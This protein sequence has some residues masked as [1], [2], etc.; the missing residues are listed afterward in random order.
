MGG[1]TRTN[2]RNGLVCCFAFGR[3]G[4]RLLA[5]LCLAANAA[6]GIAVSG[7]AVAEPATPRAGYRPLVAAADTV[8][9][10]AGVLREAPATSEL[11]LSG[12]LAMAGAHWRLSAAR[13]RVLGELAMPRQVDLFGVDAQPARLWLRRRETVPDGSPLT[14]S[15]VSFYAEGQRIVYEREPEQLVVTGQGLVEEDGKILRG[16]RLVYDLATETL[17]VAGDGG[18]RFTLDP[19]VDD[20][21]APD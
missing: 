2:C 5:G 12:G 17:R 21:L 10:E 13:G 9:I 20:V 16:E 14:R 6:V 15:T 18:V 11:F 8:S 3:R 19:A 1:P 7:L 4:P